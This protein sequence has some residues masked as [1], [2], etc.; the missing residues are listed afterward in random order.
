LMPSGVGW[1][2]LL[3]DCVYDVVVARAAEKRCQS[4]FF[5]DAREHLS[6][7][8]REVDFCG[9]GLGG[10]AEF[11]RDFDRSLCRGVKAEG[12]AAANRRNCPYARASHGTC[13]E[14][15][16]GC[17]LVVIFAFAFRSGL[18]IHRL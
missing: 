13:Q 9:S 11:L 15:T 3:G 6:A 18:L 1:N 8:H 4:F 12:S 16:P 7:G 2:S 10:Q 5:T 17:G 14:S